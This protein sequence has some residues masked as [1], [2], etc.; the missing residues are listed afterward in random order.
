MPTEARVEG[1]V[2]LAHASFAEKLFDSK[3]TQERAGLKR[4]HHDL[5][6]YQRRGPLA[7]YAPAG[8]RARSVGAVAKGGTVY[9]RQDPSSKRARDAVFKRD[10]LRLPRPLVRAIFVTLLFPG[11]G[12]HVA[13][14]A[15]VSRP[16]PT[17]ED[18]ACGPSLEAS[19]GQCLTGKVNLRCLRD[20]GGTC[21]WEVWCYIQPH[22]IY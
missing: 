7:G 3:P 4:H 8:K 21:A 1:A 10:M 14:P 20:Q 22:V 15:E 11:C 2:H 12:A 18:T 6:A 16:A 13:P 5:V 17:C 9:G 19:P